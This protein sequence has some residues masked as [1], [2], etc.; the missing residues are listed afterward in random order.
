MRPLVIVLIVGAIAVIGAG[1]YLV[2]KLGD[3]AA[4]VRGGSGARLPST[5][6]GG[7]NPALSVDAPGLGLD[8]AKPAGDAARVD[9]AA[10][11]LATLCTEL[12]KRGGGQSGARAV[13]DR[14][15]DDVLVKRALAAAHMQV[16]D[17]EVVAALEARGLQAPAPDQD[18]ALLQQ[19]MRTRLELEKLAGTQPVT[20]ADVD[21]E[22]AAGAPGIDRGAGIRVEGWIIRVPANADAAART[23]AEASAHAFAKNPTDAAAKQYGMTKLAPF[24]VGSGGIEPALEA[25]ANGLARGEVSRAIATKVGWTVIKKLDDVTGTPLDDTALR[26]RVR[27]A[28]ETR[29]QQTAASEVIGRLRRTTRIEILVAL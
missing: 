13:L 10:I 21:A 28:L 18:P 1:A 26:H 20:E 29:R 4:E 14:L 25:A 8:C 6:T 27:K 16:T 19:E 2:N 15:I 5:G 11:T 7:P 9:G 17:A 3:N 23:K 24:I 22:L 12:G